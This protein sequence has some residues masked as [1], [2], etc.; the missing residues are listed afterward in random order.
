MLK[1]LFEPGFIVVFCKPEAQKFYKD[2]PGVQ[3]IELW[4][5]FLSINR[6]V[7][8]NI[9][10]ITNFSKSLLPDFTNYILAS[11]PDTL[12]I[13]DEVASSNDSTLSGSPI[14][15]HTSGEV[16]YF[17][18]MFLAKVKEHLPP[19]QYKDEY[20]DEVCFLY[21]EGIAPLVDSHILKN[22][23]ERHKK[24]LSQYSYSENLPPGVVPRILTREFLETIP[25]GLGTDIH[26]F[27]LKNIN[28]YD[29]EIYFHPPDLRQYRFSLYP[30][31]ARDY[32]LVS[33]LVYQFRTNPNQD[34]RLEESSEEDSVESSRKDSPRKKDWKYEE[35]LPFLLKNSDKMRLSP[36]WIELEVYKG[37]EL[38][39]T[40]CPRQYLDLKDDNTPMSLDLIEKLVN[41]RNGM[42][43]EV[44]YCLGGLGEPL[45]H[46]EIPQVLSILAQ[47]NDLVEILVE[48]AL[49]IPESKLNEIF[50]KLDE[51]TRSKI[52]F[53]VN[54]T[55]NQEKK[56]SEIY[57]PST[58]AKLPEIKSNIQALRKIFSDTQIS[59]QILKIQE[60]EEE[61]DAYFDHWEKEGLNIVFQKYNS[62]AGLM[63]EKRVSD[64]TPLKRE[65]CWH[66][67]RDL[68]INAN[69][70]VSICKQVPNPQSDRILGNLNHTHLADI[71]NGNL[72]SFQN[73]LNGLHSDIPAPCL[74]C[75]EWY[76]FNA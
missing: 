17:E 11:N 34:P 63:P 33:A 39:C 29:V 66:L 9:K 59:V 45:L 18:K 28:Q 76:S 31:S 19:S 55:T 36:S 22:I 60:V 10:I 62:Y 4:D 37:C 1:L 21:Y 51:G 44:T 26:S 46:P 6:S 49:Y 2:L 50:E 5:R 41:E 72:A 16:S 74:N 69:G 47:T 65:F 7:F 8:P 25:P 40:F 54:L 71:W 23:W 32:H 20:W 14:A 12:F 38:K 43:G 53:I 73:S 15:S 75:D 3:L 35:L 42:G 27:F 67:G 61:V 24:Y 13:A 48:T 57:A 70:E 52:N 68:Y 56:Y 58:Q 64:L 30:N